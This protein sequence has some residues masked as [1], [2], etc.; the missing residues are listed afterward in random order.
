MSKHLTKLSSLIYE[1]SMGPF[2]SDIKV[3]N[4]VSDGV[5]VLNGS[6]LT[7]FKLLEDGFKYVTPEKAKTFKKA[8]AR[9]GDIVITHRGT[10]GQISFIPDNSKYEE[11]VISQ[12]QFRVAL[13]RDLVD[14]AYFVYYFHTS[15]GQK[16]LLANKCHVGVPALAQATTNFRLVE[17]HLPGL[18]KQKSI[19]SVLSSLDSKIELNN[20]INAE[21]EAMVKTLY[22]YWFMQFDFPDENGKP[23][24]SSGGKMIWCEA[25]KK[26]VPEGWE[27]ERLSN[28]VETIIDHRGKTPL[29]LG[30]DWSSDKRGVIAL[31]AKHVKDG[32]LLKLNEANV[33]TLEMFE[34]WMP[35]KLQECDVIMTSEAPCGEFYLI[36]SDTNYCLSQRLF[37]IRANKSK[38][39]PTYLYFELSKGHGFSQ[40]IGKQSGST[41]FGIRQ[42]ELKSVNILKPLIDIQKEF[43]ERVRPMLFQ[44][45][46]N[47]TQNQKLSE[48]RDW[49]L[50]MLMNG[51][52]KVMEK[53]VNKV[54]YEISGEMGMVAEPEGEMSKK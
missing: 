22:G 39:L 38:V 3:E 31:S 28:V 30:G 35:N 44:I 20:R 1:I 34:K 37:A 14:P 47:E 2:G 42:D 26:K 10:L 36:L 46:N 51:Q 4:F 32:K 17:I 19:A 40:I 15:E 49:L 27:V 33:V 5:P 16:R 29:K 48:L 25:L 18:D 8:I 54:I 11:Y 45:R 6:N 52:V 24:K 21:L 13:K 9:R 7:G 53:V 12:S 41:V 50:P 43:H 23:Y